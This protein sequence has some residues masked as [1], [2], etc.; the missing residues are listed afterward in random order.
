MASQEVLGT[1]SRRER[2][3]G[4]SGLSQV[5]YLSPKSSGSAFLSHPS[6]SPHAPVY[7]LLINCSSCLHTEFRN[8]RSKEE[9]VHSFDD[10]QAGITIT[11][12][13]IIE[14]EG[15]Y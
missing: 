5:M 11:K 7:M 6:H 15:T 2:K 9:D 4:R 12:H 10:S 1:H 14:A 3:V 8:L 13:R